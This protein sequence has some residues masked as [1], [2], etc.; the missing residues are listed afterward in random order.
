MSRMIALLV[1]VAALTVI[2]TIAEAAD[3][4]GRGWCKSSRSM[5]SFGGGKWEHFDTMYCEYRRELLNPRRTSVK[6]CL[7]I[8]AFT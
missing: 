2:S 6:T 8:G 1:G 7:H 4:C 5:V 3:G